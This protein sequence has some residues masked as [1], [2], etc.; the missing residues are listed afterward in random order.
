MLLIYCTVNEFRN[1]HFLLFSNR[2]G[3]LFIN[4][5][6]NANEPAKT[7]LSL[8]NS[9][10]NSLMKVPSHSGNSVRVYCMP[11]RSDDNML[12]RLNEY[13]F[14]VSEQQKV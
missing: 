14:V 6:K 4:C 5:K 10:L 9:M 13:P 3:N 8:S 12:F 2:R 1:L 11:A 7:F